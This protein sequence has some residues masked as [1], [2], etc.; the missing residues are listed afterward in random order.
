MSE[1][2]RKA[3]RDAL[4]HAMGFAMDNEENYSSIAPRLIPTFAGSQYGTI[5]TPITFTGDFEVDVEFSTTVAANTN[6]AVFGRSDT[7]TDFGK[8]QSTAGELVFQTDDG[9]SKVAYT[10]H[11]DGKIHKAIYYRVGNVIGIKID[12]DIK[13]FSDLGVASTV[14]IG[15]I[16][17]LFV[18]V[19]DQIFEGQILSVKFTDQSG[20]QDVITNYVFD[21]GSDLYQLPRGEGLEDNKIIGG[22]FDTDADIIPWASG[23]KAADSSRVNNRLRVINT[24]VDYGSRVYTITTEIGKPYILKGDFIY[25]GSNGWL[26]KADDAAYATGREDAIS[27]SPSSVIDGT[28]IFTA[29]ATTTYIHCVVGAGI[30]THSDYDNISVRQLPDLTC[31]L[32]NFST[33]DWFRYT[34]QRNI[35]HDAGVISEAWIGENIVVNGGFDADTNW[36]KGVGWDISAGKA[37]CDGSQISDSNLFQDSLVFPDGEVLVTL[38]VS[39]LIA[40]TV[41]VFAGGDALGEGTA[42]SSDGTY[43]E[44]LPWDGNRFYAQGNSAFVGSIDNYITQHLLE[45]A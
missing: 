1:F 42:R 21:S 10:A 30:G 33:T 43:I 20:A 36:I 40:G 16:G 44:K 25:D 15:L 11:L 3:V 5:D 14:T 22:T 39:G 7:T 23:G 2:A 38:T 27:S 34:L 17:A 18:A 31:L 8:L 41:K 13:T 26:I 4:T 24:G 32:T 28:L 37:N 29:T 45:V 19:V 9:N 12:G 35:T 6:I